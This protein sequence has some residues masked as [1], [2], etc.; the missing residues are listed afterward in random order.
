MTPWLSDDALGRLRAAGELPDLAGTKYCALQAIGRGGM[1]AI[2]LAEDTALGRRVALK[3]LDLPDAAG[4]LAARLL[5]EAQILAQLE[6]PGI[7]PVHDVGRLADGHV[8]YAM[9]FVEGRRLDEHLEKVPSLPDRLRIFLRIAEAVAFAHARGVLHRD[10]KPQNVMVGPFGEVLVMDWGVAKILRDAAEE[11]TMLQA[12]AGSA[13]LTPPATPQTAHGT[14]LGTPGYMAPEQARGESDR[15]D[16]R[17]DVYA[18]GAILQFLLTGRALA[19]ATTPGSRQTDGG[20]PPL[21]TTVGQRIPRA[22]AAICLQAMAQRPAARYASAEAL[23][24]DV[25]RYL[26]GEPVAAYPEGLLR[27]T[28][29]LLVKHRVAV[30]LLLTYMIV[31][32]LFQIFFGSR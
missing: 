15:V 21:R 9:K 18:L 4:D 1:G 32:A 10:L 8:F 7:V 26:D 27:K 6:H 30:M 13:A 5:R 20:R 11:E 25:S 29:R 28:E 19:E 17:A 24:A 3:V 12:P 14:V 23:A 31:R 2:F 22:L 16:Q